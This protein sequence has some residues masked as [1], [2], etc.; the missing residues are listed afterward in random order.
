MSYLGILYES[1][2]IDLMN[3][4]DHTKEYRVKEGS[5]GLAIEKVT[6]LQREMGY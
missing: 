2:F 6:K 5:P 1:V 4:D 3:L